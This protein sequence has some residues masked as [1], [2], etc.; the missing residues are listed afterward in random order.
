MPFAK[1]V[2]AK[3]G[4]FDENGI[5]TNIDYMRMMKIVKD[6]GYTGY[7]GIES[8]SNTDEEKAIRLTKALLEKVGQQLS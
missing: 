3:S 7:V 1:G 5:E 6:A 8:G 2:S 4:S